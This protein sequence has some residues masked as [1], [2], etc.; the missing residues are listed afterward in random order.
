[1]VTRV[2]VAEKERGRASGFH[3]EGCPDQDSAC[4]KIVFGGVTT[5][6]IE[7]ECKRLLRRKGQSEGTARS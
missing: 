3:H 6:A 1:V 4:H 7:K 5:P 2:Q